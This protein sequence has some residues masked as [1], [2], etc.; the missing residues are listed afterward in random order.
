MDPKE[1]PIMA[2]IN[3]RNIVVGNSQRIIQEIASR[4]FNPNQ[5]PVLTIQPRNV[6]LLCG[7]IVEVE[8][9]VTNGAAD[10]AN[11]TGMGTANIIQN[12]LFEDLNNVQRINTKGWHIAMLNSARRG[13]V[14]G[15]AYAPNLPMSYGNNWNVFEGANTIAADGV[16]NIKHTYHIPLAYSQED[17]RGA[18]YAGV[19]N[20][21]MNLQLTLA[22]DNQLFT[23]GNNVLNA[24]YDGN[25]NGGWTDT[26]RVTVYQVY[27]DQLPSMNGQPIL[28]LMDLN[29]VYDLKYTTSSGVTLNQ[30]FPIQYANYRE[31][32]STLAVFDNGEQFNGGDDVAYWALTAANSTNLF[33]FG[34]DIAALEARQT[35]MADPPPG[36]Y[37]FDHRRR[38]INT[39]TY[40]NMELNLNASTVNAGA[41]VLTAFESFQNSQQIGLAGSLDAS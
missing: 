15:G 19:I 20:A 8:G 18:I 24:V 7:F 3:A 40:G 23:D 28:P 35:F 2:N 32:L 14:F 25:A 12:V 6:G 16:T 33:K 41:R 31:F 5:Q 11:R 22:T 1:N 17:L 9:S 30:D 26:V 4:T 10:V 34:P 36:V 38:P 13:S 27:L 29:T 21:T 39:L 37:Y